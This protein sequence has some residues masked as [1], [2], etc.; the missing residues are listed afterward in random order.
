MGKKHIF[1]AGF[2]CD[3]VMEGTSRGSTAVDIKETVIKHDVI[4]DG[5]LAAHA[6]SG[7]DTSSQPFGIGKMKM[8]RVL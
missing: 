5:L 4:V 6:I 7:C 2:V 3:L 1:S 8:L